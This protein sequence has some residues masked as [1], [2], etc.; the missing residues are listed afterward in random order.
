MNSFMFNLTDGDRAIMNINS[1]AYVNYCDEYGITFLMWASMR[2]YTKDVKLLLDNG[3]DVNARNNDGFTSLMWASNYE[4]TEIVRLLLENGADVNAKNNDGQTALMIVCDCDE[5]Y[6]NY[7]IDLRGNTQVRI[8]NNKKII[9]NLL[10]IYGADFNLKD[11][12]NNTA[13]DLANQCNDIW[14]ISDD[15]VKILKQNII[16]QSIRKHKERQKDQTKLGWMLRG[17]KVKNRGGKL[18]YDIE[19]YIRGFIG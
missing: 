8:M 2:G 17:I 10:Q 15:I 7:F 9:I 1:G 14:T 19:Y 12:E 18:P 13:F 4:H 5:E 11:N 3:A 16:T 6:I